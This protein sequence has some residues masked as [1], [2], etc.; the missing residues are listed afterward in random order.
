MTDTLKN[1]VNQSLQ[2]SPK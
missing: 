2:P 1:I